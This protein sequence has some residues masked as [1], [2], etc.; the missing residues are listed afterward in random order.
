MQVTHQLHNQCIT[1]FRDSASATSAGIES[2]SV[3]KQIVIDEEDVYRVT[4]I[5][6]VV[7]LIIL[8]IGLIIVKA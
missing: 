5:S 4:G 2:Q 6:I 7:L 1:K 3:V 8:T